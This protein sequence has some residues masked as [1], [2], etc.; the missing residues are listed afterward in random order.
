MLCGHSYIQVLLGRAEAS[1]TLIM[2]RENRCTYVCMYLS[3]YVAIR[4]PRVRH[5]RACSACGNDLYRDNVC[6]HV[7]VKIVNVII[8]LRIRRGSLVPRP[9]PLRGEGSGEKRQ[10]PWIMTSFCNVII[11]MKSIEHDTK[12]IQKYSASWL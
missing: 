1:P 2:L 11:I 6:A 5:A 12:E 9:H 3:I 10:D 7:M 4:R 8:C